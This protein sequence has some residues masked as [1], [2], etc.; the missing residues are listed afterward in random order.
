MLPFQVKPH[1]EVCMQRE[2]ECPLDCKIQHLLARELD[3]HIAIECINRPIKCTDCTEFYP[4]KTEKKHLEE[5]CTMRLVLCPQHC[6]EYIPFS[7]LQ[8]HFLFCAF[9]IIKCPNNQCSETFPFAKKSKHLKNEC[10]YRKVACPLRCLALVTC[11]QVPHHVSKI[12]QLRL[13]KCKWCAEEQLFCDLMNHENTC[14]KRGVA[15]L[16]GC[17][18][19][20]ADNEMKLHLNESCR[21]RF[22]P[23]EIRCGQKVRVVD[24]TAHLSVSCPNRLVPCPNECFDHETKKTRHVISKRMQAHLSVEC[25]SRLVLCRLCTTEMMS[26][27]VQSHLDLECSQRLVGCRIQGC[28]KQVRLVDRENHELHECKF[29]LILCENG[30]DIRILNIHMKSHIARTCEM[31]YVTCPLQ[32]GQQV[33]RRFLRNHLSSECDKCTKLYGP[34][35]SPEK[36]PQK[37]RRANRSKPKELAAG[38]SRVSFNGSDD[39][40]SVGSTAS[41]GSRAGPKGG[42]DLVSVTDVFLSQSRASTSHVDTRSLGRS[43]A[44]GNSSLSLFDGM[45]PDGSTTAIST[46][47]MLSAEENKLPHM[48]SASNSKRMT[49]SANKSSSNQNLNSGTVVVSPSKQ[50]NARFE[51]AIDEL[52]K[53]VDAA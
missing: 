44:T 36:A 15:C 31:R 53:Q 3:E 24:M 38:S 51:T 1:L 47:S 46:S 50:K 16:A 4:W 5:L 33:R 10:V 48:T 35:S 6:E 21:H 37:K 45:Y 34:S 27:S 28:A 12:C 8:K 40:L 20:I 43:V 11:I 2:V 14:H 19:Y 22:I 13:E 30:C 26:C 9:R 7:E 18:E 17:G 29:R 49:V 39:E 41:A 32:C 23:C 25:P 42:S 52:L